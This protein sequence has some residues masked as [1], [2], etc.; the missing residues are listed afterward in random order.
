MTDYYTVDPCSTS[1]AY[2]IKF[3]KKFNLKKASV[4]LSQIGEII[5]ETPVVMVV[6]LNDVS[7]SVYST[8]RIM[9]TRV[10]KKKTGQM[11]EKIHLLFQKFDCYED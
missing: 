6:K 5:A 1:N 4:A 11:A 7:M 2:E 3:T 8:G 10:N 9:L